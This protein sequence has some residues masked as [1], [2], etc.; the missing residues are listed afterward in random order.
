MPAGVEA[1]VGVRMPWVGAVEGEPGR[2]ELGVPHGA[3]AESGV[4]PGFEPMGSLGMP[5][6]MESDAHVG[7]PGPVLRCAEGA[8]HTGATQREGRRRTLGV[9]PPGGGQAPGGVPRGFPGGASESQCL[10]GEGNVPI[11]GAL[12]SVEMALE[13]RPVDLGTLQ[14]EGCME[15]EAP[16]RDRGE[17]DVVVARGGG[18]QAS[19]H[20]LPTEDGGEPVCRLR[21]QERPRVPSACADVL[22]EEADAAGAHAHG[23]WGEAVGGWVGALGQQADFSDRGCLRPFACAAEVESRNHV[24]TQGAH[25]ISPFVRRVVGLR[26]KTS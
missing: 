9:L 22:R 3:L 15:P 6:G 18:R 8:L 17:G 4:P 23:R 7:D 10:G 1:L 11:F 16:A 13:A 5:Q 12:P 2:C 26:R 24:L 14:E 20:F 21:A 19:P 25:E